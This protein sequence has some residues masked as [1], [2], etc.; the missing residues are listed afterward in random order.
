MLSFPEKAL[1]PHTPLTVMVDGCSLLRLKELGFSECISHRQVEP[2]LI[3][4]V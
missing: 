1:L 3:L 4:V 2:L